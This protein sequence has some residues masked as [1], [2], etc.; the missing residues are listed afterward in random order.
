[1]AWVHLDGAA[2]FPKRTVHV[3]IHLECAGEI[4][5]DVGVARIELDGR[6]ILLDRQRGFAGLQQ[7]VAKIVMRIGILWVKLQEF[8][9]G[10][11]RIGE[12]S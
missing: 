2:V 9:V 1:M 7:G 5:M 4:H 3:A 10:G 11:R 6:S 8:L 12:P